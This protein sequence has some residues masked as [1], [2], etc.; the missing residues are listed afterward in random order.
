MAF[1]AV[2]S[3]SLTPPTGAIPARRAVVINSSGEVALAAANASPAG[4]TLE[5]SPDSATAGVT[6]LEAQAAIPVALLDGA[7]IEVE[8]NAAIALGARVAVAGTGADAGRVDDTASGAGVRYI[9]F[10]LNATSA[11]GE[12]CTVLCAPE[13]GSAA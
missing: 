2:R 7:K 12:V 8:A 5:A 1:E 3:I 4:I 10:A 9:G 6:T 11:A 13:I